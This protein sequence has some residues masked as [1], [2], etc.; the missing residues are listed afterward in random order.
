[1]LLI[2][3]GRHF[4]GCTFSEACAWHVCML[5]DGL[6]VA[7]KRRQHACLTC[8]YLLLR[9]LAL[10]CRLQAVLLAVCP[11]CRLQAA[12]R[13]ISEAVSS[14][15]VFASPKAAAYWTYHLSRSSFF[16]LQGAAGA[17]LVTCSRNMICRWKANR[18]PAGAVPVLQA[19]ACTLAFTGLQ[20]R[21]FCSQ[22]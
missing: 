6:V 21:R 4:A 19:V 14:A 7:R 2:S 11:A 10:A 5:A 15:G 1:M 3:S 12:A 18:G 20:G 13:V 22:I 8:S 16:L 9:V 17:V